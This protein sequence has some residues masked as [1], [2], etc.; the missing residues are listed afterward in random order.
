ME[1]RM[2]S[3]LYKRRECRFQGI[4][5]EE[6]HSYTNIQ[7]YLAIN[8]IVKGNIY[9]YTLHFYCCKADVNRV[10]ENTRFLWLHNPRRC[11]RIHY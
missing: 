8:Y 4:Y 3:I 5:I 2:N 1:L 6:L 7:K 9:I 10:D 11:T